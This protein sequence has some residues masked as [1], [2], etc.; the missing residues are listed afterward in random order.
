MD[1]QFLYVDN[2]LVVCSKPVGVSSESPGLPDLVRESLNRSV[3]PVHRLDQTTGGACV[4]ALSPAVCTQMQ[5]QFT[6][7]LVKKEYLAIIAGSPD[8][9]NGTYNDLL[10][11]DKRVNKTFVVYRQRKGVKEASC[12]WK[13]IRSVT[14]G[15]QLLS[16]MR[17]SLHTGR[18]HQ[19]RVQFS[20]R[21]YPL[22]G[23]K[24]YGSRL[25]AKSPSLWACRIVFDHPVI[26]GKSVDAISVPPDCYPWNLFLPVSL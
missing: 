17:V 18:T 12:D 2:D 26:K 6:Q 22:V 15:D 4:L 25:K 1:I 14:D 9:E 13:H 21:G 16:L 5:K 10:F 23:D 19:I 8:S 7:D 3:Y 24:K 11:H 20:S